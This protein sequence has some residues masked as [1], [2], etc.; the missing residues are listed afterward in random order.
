M[1]QALWVE[2]NHTMTVNLVRCECKKRLLF[3]SYYLCYCS[4]EK[5]WIQV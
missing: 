3:L 2:R 4:K 5:A 1:Q